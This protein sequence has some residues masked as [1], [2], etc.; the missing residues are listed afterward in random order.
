MRDELERCTGPKKNP[1]ER[2]HRHSRCCPAARQLPKPCEAGCANASRWGLA[3]Y[4]ITYTYNLKSK[5]EVVN[6]DNVH[7]EL[8]AHIFRHPV[9]PN[10][11]EE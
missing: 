2:G 3:S 1:E 4:G 7:R 5:Q 9:P 10:E 6:S 11:F 8:R